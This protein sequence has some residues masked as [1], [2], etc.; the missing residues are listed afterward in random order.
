MIRNTYF[1]LVGSVA[2]T[3]LL[4]S[5]SDSFLE[6]KKLYGK[7]NYNTVYNN[8][9]TAKN[10]VDNLYYQMLPGKK[11]GQGT[12]VAIVSTGTNDEF[13]KTTEEFGGLS[14]LEDNQALLDYNDINNG[15][16]FV[17]DHFYVENK[18]TSPWGYLRNINDCIEGL[19]DGSLSTDEKNELLGQAY[20]M[21]AW[22]YFTMV[23][24]YGGVPIIDHVQE[25]LVSKISSGSSIVVPRASTL[26]CIEFMYEDL[27]KA[28]ELLPATWENEASD[29][30]R[31]TKGTAAALKGRI[32]LLWASPLFNRADDQKRWQ[33]A[34][35]INK[36]ALTLLAAGGYGL[37]YENNPGTTTESAANWAKIF[38]DLKGTDGS[39]NE[40]IFVTLYN[41]IDVTSN[42]THQWNSW[43]NTI[44]PRNA[45]AG[46]G[47]QPTSEMIDAFP[48]ADGKMNGES[49]FE[50]D[51]L[52]FFKDRDP[53][54]YRTFTFPGEW[55]RFSGT[56]NST[57]VD[58][59]IASL[60]TKYPNFS[61]WGNYPYDGNEYVFWGYTW[62]ASEDNQ[63]SL[64]KSGY[65][66]DMLGS[67]NASVLVRKRSDDLQINTAPL[68]VY[69]YT[70]SNQ[71]FRQSASP[72]IEIRYA[73]VLLNFAEAAAAI[74]N[75]TEAFDALKRIRS[76]VYNQDDISQC[77]A[78]YGLTD[79][80]DRAQAIAQVL[81]ER[82]I[83]LAYEGKRFEDMRRWM[84]FDGG[85]GQAALKDTWAL[86]GFGGNTCTY[87]GLTPTNGH[88][89]H[90]L[91][92]YVENLAAVEEDASQDPI[93]ID[94]NTRPTGL[95]PCDRIN[96]QTDLESFYTDY[97]LRKNRNADGNDET[98]IP[99]FQPYYY[100]CGLC[101]SAMYNNPT[102]YQTI[103]WEDYSH[104][105]DGIYDPLETDPDKIPVDNTTSSVSFE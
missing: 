63:A 1:Y 42:N 3:V 40:N 58:R 43:E 39:V 28:I 102:L 19:K 2:A 72:F 36:E 53:R 100:F 23:K 87:L 68:Y 86:T 32:A 45:Y 13:A 61:Y 17:W 18:E 54:F 52:C 5:C 83:E 25:S 51:S 34:Y 97:L 60:E 98:Q 41:N 62:Y 73:E 64:S 75:H 101:Y 94:G 6:E 4:G 56:P 81:N 35:D 104:G 33:D 38:L 55:W 29:W 26:E 91:E 48:M 105:G 57:L 22:R 11:E 30:G 90:Y 89:N 14:K 8:Y 27:D 24:W 88:K 74:N 77:N 84:L 85:A 12:G 66:A 69:T 71:G 79:Y 96:T 49:V 80:T 78:D 47:L 103:G 59:S 99:T 76:R 50:Y 67:N 82:K 95:N 93:L 10:R 16:S 21:R 15:G 44:R 20:F 7:Y 31:V 46:G 65:A 37:A 70:T 9:E 92:I